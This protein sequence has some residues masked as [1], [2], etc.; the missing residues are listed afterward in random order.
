MLELHLFVLT[1]CYWIAKA[2]LTDISKCACYES[3]SELSSYL[4]LTHTR[5]EKEFTTVL[6][7]DA[8]KRFFTPN[9]QGCIWTQEKISARIYST[10]ENELK[11]SANEAALWEP[12]D[13]G[14]WFINR[15]EFHKRTEDGT[16]HWR[17]P[18]VF[19]RVYKYGQLPSEPSQDKSTSSLLQAL[20]GMVNNFAS[21]MRMLLQ[22]HFVVLWSMK[23]D[24][25]GHIRSVS[26]KEITLEN[27][28]FE[29]LD[30]ETR[31]NST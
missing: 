10:H 13:D 20:T 11:P 22:A 6:L 4:K 23:L 1:N 7:S 9:D 25:R 18:L 12:L 19:V 27:R 5:H 21:R 16:Y 24:C 8:A 26:I 28:S 17:S 2:R 3:L 14:V 29:K 30:D 15:P 31:K